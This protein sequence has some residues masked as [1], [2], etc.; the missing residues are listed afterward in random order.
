MESKA[1]SKGMTIEQIL[2]SSDSDPE[3]KKDKE[4]IKVINDRL[5]DIEYIRNIGERDGYQKPATFARQ[6]RAM[7]K[8]D[9]DDTSMQYEEAR[10]N[11]TTPRPAWN[12]L[13]PEQQNAFI[14]VYRKKKSKKQHSLI[15]GIDEKEPIY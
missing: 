2:N 7:W 14:K 5:K 13:S 3:T 8:K 10:K 9:W 15:W 11:S 6:Q 12:R 4:E 1:A